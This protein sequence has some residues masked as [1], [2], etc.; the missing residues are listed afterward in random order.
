M[1]LP[2]AEGEE[3]PACRQRGDA[4]GSGPG[5]GDDCSPSGSEDGSSA[6]GSEGGGQQ[7]GGGRGGEGAWTPLALCEA[8]AD[9][10][11]WRGRRGGRLDIYRAANWILRA[12]LGG[13]SNVCLAF[14]P[15][16][17]RRV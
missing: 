17:Q 12:A 6:A 4:A 7:E 2:P 5:D 13:K 8:F 16:E 10:H 9:K 15:A 1:D 3:G 11:S 14:L